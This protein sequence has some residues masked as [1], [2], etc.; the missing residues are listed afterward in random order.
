MLDKKKK[1]SLRMISPRSHTDLTSKRGLASLLLKV[2]EELSLYQCHARETSI[3]RLLN[4]LRDPYYCSLGSLKLW[5]LSFSR[6][7]CF[8]SYLLVFVRNT[9]NSNEQI[10]IFFFF[11]STIETRIFDE[12]HYKS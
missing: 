1:K 5:S 8:R 7:C 2:I 10:T 9:Q 3:L 12:I 6:Q 4:L 11:S